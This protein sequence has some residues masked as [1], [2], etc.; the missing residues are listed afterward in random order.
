MK[1][2]LF[3]GQGSQ[4]EKMGEDFYL[5]DSFAKDFYD[6]LDDDLKDIILNAD[7]DT[8]SKTENTQPA[9][10]AYQTMISEL[11]K[12]DGIN[13]DYTAGLSIGEYASLAYSG[14]ITSEEAIEIAKI[15]GKLMA[16]VGANLNS[17]MIAVLGMDEETIEKYCV[18]VSDED[19]RVEISNLN[20]P[21]QIVVSG[22]KEAL[23][24]L[25]ISIE[26]QAR[27][28]V[29]LN[30]SGPFHTTYM[31]Q[32]EAELLDLFESYEF[33][34]EQVEIAYNLVGR[35]REDDEDLKGIM[36]RQV[37][38]TVRFQECIEYLLER[39][40][41]TFVEVG[42]GGVLRGFVRKIDRNAKVYV[43]DSVENYENFVKE[44]KNG[45]E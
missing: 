27:R 43:I 25:K 7:L 38:H 30:T 3:A 21:G 35:P 22:D 17:G 9:M 5:S 2:I 31:I 11:F 29:E 16:D 20:C 44:V 34:E 45:R 14:V 8:I 10:I 23:D 15:R 36:A 28:L 26:D 40:V 24:R 33:K 6:K 18:E 13:F 39:G 4:Q 42:F 41:N 1:A 19:S 12:E 32:V 37:S